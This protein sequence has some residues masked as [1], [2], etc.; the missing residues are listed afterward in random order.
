MHLRVRLDVLMTEKYL[1]CSVIEKNTYFDKKRETR[2][3]GTRNPFHTTTHHTQN[4]SET[5]SALSAL[6]LCSIPFQHRRS[7]RS[8][9]HLYEVRSLAEVVHPAS[10][11]VLSINSFVWVVK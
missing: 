9:A 7:Y 2:W 10:I 6:S 1:Y 5:L 8:K 3:S 11:E 4:V